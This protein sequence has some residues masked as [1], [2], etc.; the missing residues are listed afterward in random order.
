[1]TKNLGSA[2]LADHLPPASVR[3]AAADKS[4]VPEE[5]TT[6]P[7]GLAAWFTVIVPTRDE[8]ANVKP[9]LARLASSMGDAVAEVLFVDDSSDG[10]ADAIRTAGRHSGM[11]V[12]LIHRGVKARPGGLSGAVVLGLTHARGTWAVVMDGD[13][14]HPPELVARMVAIGQARGLDL[15]V[16]SRKIG[17][18]RSDGLS[19]GYRHTIS[20]VS[21]LAAKTLFPH[22]LSRLSDPMSGFFA[23][24]LAALDLDRLRPTGFK[25]LLEIAVRQPQLLVAEVPF[26]FGTRTEGQSK[27]SIREGLRYLRHLSRLRLDVLKKQIARSSTQSPALRLRRLLAF[28]LVGVSGLVVN[29][30]ALWLLTEGLSDQHYLLAAVLATQVSTAWNLLWTEVFVFSGAKPGTR[31]SRGIKFFLLNN[32]ALLL[33]IP[34]L[35]FL[36]EIV[37][38]NLLVANV[39]TLVLLFLV[40]FLI[41]DAAIYARPAQDVDKRPMR[42]VVTPAELAPAPARRHRP[43][44]AGHRHLPYRYAIHDLLTI[45]SHV[46]LPELEYFRAQWVGHDVDLTIR[47]GQV[48]RSAPRAHAQMTQYMSPSGLRY[49][50]HLGRLGANFKVDIGDRVDVLVSPALARS[51]HVLYTNVI[52]ALLRFLTVSKG[53]ILLHS[54]CMELNGEGFLLSAR[55]DTGKTGTVLRMLREQGALF[56]SDDMTIVDSQGMAS[57]FPKPLTISHHTLRAVQVGD[58]TPAEWRRL[59]VQSRLHSKEGRDFAM[60]LARL[61]IPIMGFNSMTQRIVPPP[62]YMVDRLVDCK[63]IRNTH[64]ENLFVIERGAPSLSEIDPK[65]A[66][67]TLVV[68]TDDAYGFPPFREMAPSIVIGHDDYAELRHKE[69]A[70]LASAMNGVRVRG[71]A[72]DDF[73]WADRIATL[74]GSSTQSHCAAEVTNGTA[75]ANAAM[76]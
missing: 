76:A 55:T 21:T 13:L 57:C 22:R 70:I 41:A 58:L 47:V 56:L 69:E 39:F 16:G 4:V 66:L 62:K 35:A 30:A 54:A 50:E 63:I 18:G 61:N 67:Q 2:E 33:R 23:V 73:S 37:H 34:L 10:T 32:A 40:R 25:I 28:G 59:R 60:L 42:I 12:R 68:N 5:I 6:L 49:E 1:M 29:T 19:S 44:P 11:A 20:G 31:L 64:I 8:A 71:I 45:G 26:V 51:P 48:G 3:T 7:P 9:L 17:D 72:S 53:S 75:K 27:A 46:P 36:V 14:Q 52:E 74:L 43:S 65:S 38:V 15:V 24:R